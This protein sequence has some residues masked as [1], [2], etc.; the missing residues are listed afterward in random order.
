MIYTNFGNNREM[1]GSGTVLFGYL[2]KLDS[3]CSLSRTE[4]W[5]GN[6]NVTWG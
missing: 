5:G 6:D 2:T 3:R 1:L 4:M